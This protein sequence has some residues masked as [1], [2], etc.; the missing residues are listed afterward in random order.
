M[1]TLSYST[2][3]A[4]TALAEKYSDPISDSTF[5]TATTVI[6][7]SV[8][9]SLSVYG[10]IPDISEFPSFMNPVLTEY[11]SA[12][13][14]GPPVWS[15]TRAT[16]CEICERDWVPLTYHHLIPK[17][18]HGKALKRKW[19]EEWMLNSVAW[20][21][22]ACHSFV[23]RMASNEELAKEWFSVEKILQRDDVQRWAAWVAR[24]RWRAK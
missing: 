8:S 11:I 7:P 12:V 5:D 19:H 2:L 15:N 14:A 10:F 20:L 3:Q 17:A 4:D 23:H 9:E 18:V 16:S 21:C 24:I 13:S 1:Q 22:R 6:S